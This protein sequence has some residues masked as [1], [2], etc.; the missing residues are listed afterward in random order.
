M[1][2]RY[3]GNYR[4]SKSFKVMQIF[5]AQ[6]TMVSVN[7]NQCACKPSGFVPIP[8][9]IEKHTLSFREL[10]SETMRYFPND[11]GIGSRYIRIATF[12]VHGA[13][14]ITPAVYVEDVAIWKVCDQGIQ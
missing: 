3:F 1:Y 9:R 13:D 10:M 5:C 6:G 14:Q 11:F 12:G 7:P 8:Q 4:I 2:P